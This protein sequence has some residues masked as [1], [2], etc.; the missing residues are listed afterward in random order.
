MVGKA[1]AADDAMIAVRRPSLSPTWPNRM[2][3][4]GRMTKPTAKTLNA[5]ISETV[6]SSCGKNCLPMTTA[7]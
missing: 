3:P 7:K 1:I 2:P 4:I 6:G 5:A